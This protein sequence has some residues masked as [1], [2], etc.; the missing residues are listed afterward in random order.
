MA[1]KRAGKLDRKPVTKA[2]KKAAKGFGK[3]AKPTP[4]GAR[5]ADFAAGG[6]ADW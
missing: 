4:R 5:K 3:A 2:Q 6:V 1:K